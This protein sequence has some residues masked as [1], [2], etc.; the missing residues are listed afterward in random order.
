MRSEFT[1]QGSQIMSYTAN[2][3]NLRFYNPHLSHLP[4]REEVKGNRNLM[5]DYSILKLT[6]KTD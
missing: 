5:T 6:G 1:V 4:L 2:G 3:H